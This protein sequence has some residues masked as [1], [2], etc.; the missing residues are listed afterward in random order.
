VGGMVTEKGCYV[1]SVGSFQLF[2]NSGG[3]MKRKKLP[4]GMPLRK[5][6][7]TSSREKKTALLSA[8]GVGEKDSLDAC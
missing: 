6:R 3:R 4:A 1:L 7:E 2:L 8:S 5:E